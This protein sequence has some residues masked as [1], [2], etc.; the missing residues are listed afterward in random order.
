[1]NFRI[2]SA[3]L[4]AMIVTGCKQE[5]Y[6]EIEQGP[7]TIAAQ[8]A[9]QTERLDAQKAIQRERLDAQKAARDA[10]EAERIH[11]CVIGIQKYCDS[12]DGLIRTYSNSRSRR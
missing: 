2:M 7:N 1:M 12:Q 10:M 9:M 11:K 8:R 6:L 3:L 5:K 4:V